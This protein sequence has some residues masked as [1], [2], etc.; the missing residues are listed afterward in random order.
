[1]PIPKTGSS[2]IDRI[3]PKPYL[4]Y[5]HPSIL[6]IRKV[7]KKGKF[8]SYFKFGFVRNPWSLAVSVF[9]NRPYTK[10][11]TWGHKCDNFLDF[12][13][14]YDC[15]SNYCKFEFGM[16]NQL[17]WLTDKSGKILVDFIGKFENLK[18]D[19]AIVAN[20]INLKKY[21][22]PHINKAN[23]S[24]RKHYTKYYNNETIEIVYNNFK[25]DI[26]HFGYTFKK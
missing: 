4:P 22:F 1:V 15:A 16:K 19:F 12:V 9:L 13:K 25:K 23:D 20:R 8:N 14:S 3:I 18:K 26:K 6:E 24:N 5:P 17:S 10:N 11:R 21:N 7:L 2:S